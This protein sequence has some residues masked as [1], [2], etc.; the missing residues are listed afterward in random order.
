[1]EQ[2]RQRLLAEFENLRFADRWACDSMP[3][4]CAQPRT[5]Q[6]APPARPHRLASLWR[7]ATDLRNARTTQTQAPSPFASP[8]QQARPFDRDTFIY[9]AKA[10]TARRLNLTPSRLAT[11]SQVGSL[12]PLAM[13]CVVQTSF[14]EWCSCT[15]TALLLQPHISSLP[16]CTGKDWCGLICATVTAHR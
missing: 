2:S 4:Q 11:C 10:A 7:S 16:P 12:S 9:P 15:R 1:M 5:P 14:H 13:C 3:P 8:D 6:P